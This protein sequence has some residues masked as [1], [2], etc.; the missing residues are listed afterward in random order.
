MLRRMKLEGTCEPRSGYWVVKVAKLGIFGYGDSPEDARKRADLA[1]DMLFEHWEKHGVLEERLH[2]AG[3]E[4]ENIK[5]IHWSEERTR[6]VGTSAAGQMAIT[7][8]A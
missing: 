7:P 5:H 6:K 2:K 3:V 8:G 1:C 4:F